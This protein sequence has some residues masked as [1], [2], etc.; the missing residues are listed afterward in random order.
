MCRLGIGI[1]FTVCT[2]KRTVAL[3][4]FSFRITPIAISTD[5]L[6]RSPEVYVNEVLL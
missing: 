4:F 3:T 1:A 6:G 2:I 5:V